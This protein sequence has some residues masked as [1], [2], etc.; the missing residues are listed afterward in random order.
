VNYVRWE[1]ARI[2]VLPTPDH[3]RNITLE[4]TEEIKFDGFRALAY[5]EDGRCRL[6]SRRQHEYKSFRTLQS[7][8]AGLPVENAV[9]DGELVCPDQFGRP[10]FYELL[11]RRADPYFYAFD[12]LWLNGEDM[13]ELQLLKRKGACASSSIDVDNRGFSTSIIAR[14]TDPDCFRRFAR[15]TWKGLSRTRSDIS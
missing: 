9:L 11:F 7:G 13:R 3:Q 15:S 12:L 8:L 1:Q 6:V 4:A 14:K 2:L 5:I 10:Q